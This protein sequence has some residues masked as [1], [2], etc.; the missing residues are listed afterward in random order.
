MAIFAADV[1]GDG[2]LD[3]V[4]PCPSIGIVASLAGNGDGTF[5]APVVSPVP[6]WPSTPAVLEDFNRDGKPDLALGS[7]FD[8]SLG[9]ISDGGV[10]VLLG[11]G[12]GTFARPEIFLPGAPVLELAAGDLFGS[13]T[14]PALL[15]STGAALASSFSLNV[16]VGLGDGSFSR[17]P[18]LGIGGAPPAGGI[19]RGGLAIGAIRS[20]GGSEVLLSFAPPAAGAALVQAFRG[21]PDGGLSAGPTSPLPGAYVVELRDISGDGMGDLVGIGGSSVA[22]ALGKGDGT[23][24]QPKLFPAGGTPIDLGVAD[25]N[26]DGNLDIAVV[27][28]PGPPVGLC[29]QRG[30]ASVGILL[31]D[32]K[33]GFAAV[34]SFALSSAGS[35][36]GGLAVGDLDGDGKPDVATYDGWTGEVYVLLDAWRWAG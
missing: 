36:V 21:S 35:G 22:V 23:F 30:G 31:G 18:S 19:V 1:T 28:T 13:A 8:P 10:A 29:R 11:N 16:L 33:G 15:V 26:G 12:D 2:K 24:L 3:L 5:Q 4:T 6:A 27:T 34:E 20:D 7:F 14:P 32:G 17:G 9:S 25:F